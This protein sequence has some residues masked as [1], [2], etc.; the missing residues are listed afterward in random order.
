MVRLLR[1]ASKDAQ[2]VAIVKSKKICL[3]FC[4]P[5]QDSF[6][7]ALCDSYLAGAKD[8][9]HE[10]RVLDLYQMQFD[11]V[12]RD[13]RTFKQQEEPAIIE[14]R[15]VIDWCEHIVLVFPVWWFSL[16]ALLKGFLD[17][18]LVPGF[19]YQFDGPMIWRK[20]LRGR[21]ARVFC[22][23]DSPPIIAKLSGDPVASM[24]KFGTLGF[25]GFK[26]VT[27]NCFGP[28]K[29]SCSWMRERWLS[30]VKHLGKNAA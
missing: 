29:L 6:N 28:L 27:I 9:G 21:S 14:A 15:Q 22:T 25:V 17:R 5:D 2:E 20:L 10:V 24:L 4:H 3:V 12:L 7:R 11:P 8:S 1:I 19:A 16:P 18:V 26:P 30:E 23:M 13:S